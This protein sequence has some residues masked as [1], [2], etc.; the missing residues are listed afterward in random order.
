MTATS[1]PA[2]SST[3]HHIFTIGSIRA[4]TEEP[5]FCMEA[6]GCYHQA[7]ANFLHESGQRVSVVNPLQIKRFRESKFVRQKTDKS[8][9]C[10][11]SVFFSHVFD[12]GH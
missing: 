3:A 5:H 7:L 11:C 4:K 1:A 2:T 8:D 12:L 10:Y 6:T 9:A